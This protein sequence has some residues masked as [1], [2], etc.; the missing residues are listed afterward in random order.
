MQTMLALLFGS[1]MGLSLGLTGGG[2][3]ILAVPLLVYGLGMEL[4]AAVAVSLA[5]VGLT[6]LFGATIQ[7]RSGQVLW[8]AGMLLGGG[9]IV[10]A[11]LGARLGAA[12]PDDMVLI[13]F[14]VLMIVVGVRMARGSSDAPE[15]P[16]GRFRCP[17]GDDGRPQPTLACMAKLAAAGALAGVLSGFFGVGGGFLLVPALVWVGSVRIEHALATSLV[18]IALI[19]VSGFAANVGA[20]G[21]ISL[22]V[23]ALFG[24]GGAAGMIIGARL[25]RYLSPQVLSRVFAA[26]AIV[27]GFYVVMQVVL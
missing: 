5:V 11:P 2:G 23:A 3:S 4:R 1:A 20:A 6:A 13:L 9:G 14:A 17:R 22:S 8:R 10:A 12:M 15:L 27:A 19:S 26:V 7:A 16:L 18:A 21:Q 25:K 24:A